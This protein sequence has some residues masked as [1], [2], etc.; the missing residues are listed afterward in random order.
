MDSVNLNGYA[1]SQTVKKGK[2]V[3]IKK[4]MPRTKIAE[5]GHRGKSMPVEL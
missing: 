2:V 3:E 1:R 5:F 4:G